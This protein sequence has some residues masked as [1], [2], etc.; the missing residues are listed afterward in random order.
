MKKRMMTRVRMRVQIGRRYRYVRTRRGSI[1]REGMEGAMVC[2]GKRLAIRAL[3][4]E[5]VVRGSG[6]VLSET[7]TTSQGC[8]H[9]RSFSAAG[10]I[11]TTM[12]N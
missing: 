3:S 6:G 1:W 2:A 8:G 5:V 11:S 9:I 7:L 10:S 4:A 12:S